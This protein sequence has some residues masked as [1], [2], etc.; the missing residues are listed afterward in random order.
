LSR[1]WEYTCFRNRERGPELERRRQM[2]ESGS[3]SMPGL[4]AQ[5]IKN[6][7]RERRVVLSEHESKEVLRVYGIPVTRE[8]EARN[9]REFREALGYIGFPLVIKGAAT[10]LAH[11]TEQGLVYLDIRN[12][13]EALM[14]FVEIMDKMKGE[15]PVI[16]IQEM[17]RGGR[18]LMA[19]LSRDIQFGPSVVFGL[20]G[21]Y[22][23]ILKDT[24]FR[25]AP[26]ERQEALQMISDIKAQNIIG[27]FRGMKAADVEQLAD[28]LVSVGAIG[29]NHPDIK[30]IDINPLILSEGTFVAADALIVVDGQAD[31]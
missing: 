5:I 11:K 21:I 2:G 14:A 6:A 7:V 26:L 27:A 9:E 12:E 8:R 18:E 13:K 24:A 28:I 1:L 10:G 30:E 15:K 25:I 16:L 31:R 22:A 17:I 3:T 20:G 29:L 4:S 19:G 23:E